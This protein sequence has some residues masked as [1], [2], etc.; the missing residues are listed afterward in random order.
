MSSTFLAAAAAALLTGLQIAA[1]VLLG[2]QTTAFMIGWRVPRHHPYRFVARR[3]V[4]L[5]TPGPG[6]HPLPVRFAAFVGLLFSGPALGAAA[7][8]LTAAAAT[9]AL[10]CAIAAALNAFAHLCLACLL[11][12]RLQRLSNKLRR[13][14]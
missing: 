13:R 10:V 2:L 1:I 14:R 4:G 8:G 5:F 11:Y 7:A 6:E 12:P 3:I 9:L